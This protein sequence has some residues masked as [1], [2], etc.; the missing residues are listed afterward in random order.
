MAIFLGPGTITG[1][2]IQLYQPEDLDA[3]LKRQEDCE[4]EYILEYLYS[5]RTTQQNRYMWGVVVAR[6]AKQ[7]GLQRKVAH[8]MLKATFIPPH[9]VQSG[10]IRGWVSPSGLVIGAT[11]RQLTGVEFF[12]Y[13]ERIAE[14]AAAH[15][16]GLY[17]PPPDPLW[18]LHA[19]QELE[20]MKGVQPGEVPFED[21]DET[22]PVV[23]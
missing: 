19:E 8:D 1:G 13:L 5:L 4:I 17:I 6:V 3:V 9:L 20:K 23:H 7:L 18:K 22:P 21:D 14:H 10:R 11:T 2:K 12:D 16:G 15:W